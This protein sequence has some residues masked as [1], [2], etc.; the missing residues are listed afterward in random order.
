MERSGYFGLRRN[1]KREYQV[2]ELYAVRI[3]SLS[4]LSI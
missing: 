2:R 4:S 1:V 3:L